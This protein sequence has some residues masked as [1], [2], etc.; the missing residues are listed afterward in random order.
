MQNVLSI[1]YINRNLTNTK[2]IA[3]VKERSCQFMTR[4]ETRLQLA[5]LSEFVYLLNLYITLLSTYVYFY[6]RNNLPCAMKIPPEW[7]KLDELCILRRYPHY[8][9]STYEI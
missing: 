1:I 9:K 4:N 7:S 5:S 6:P 2:C 8:K 3:F